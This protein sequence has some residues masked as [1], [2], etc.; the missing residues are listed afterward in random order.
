MNKVLFV[1]V[2]KGKKYND[3]V[4]CNDITEVFKKVLE[5]VPDKNQVAQLIADHEDL[6]DYRPC[7]VYIDY[8]P[9]EAADEFVKKYGKMTKLK[10]IK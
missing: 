10:V 4:L 3:K 1:G 2:P 6:K 7:E 8:E 5:I 9:Q